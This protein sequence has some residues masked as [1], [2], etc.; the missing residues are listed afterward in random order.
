MEITKPTWQPFERHGNL[1]TQSDLP[2]TVLRFRS[3][4]K[5]H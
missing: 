4:G 5:N 2:D 1:T 3:S